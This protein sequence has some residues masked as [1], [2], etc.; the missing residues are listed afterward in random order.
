MILDCV[1]ILHN[2]YNTINK[3]CRLDRIITNTVLSG[4][5][6]PKGRTDDMTKL[7]AASW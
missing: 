4:G 5:G 1:V 7:K 6:S 2:N 3:D